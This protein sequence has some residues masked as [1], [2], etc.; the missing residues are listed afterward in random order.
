MEDEVLDDVL[1][2]AAPMPR[3][4]EVGGGEEVHAAKT[5]EGSRSRLREPRK[6]ET[7]QEKTNRI[8]KFHARR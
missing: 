8:K 4:D 6:P 2:G 3:P 1:L 7:K 5:S